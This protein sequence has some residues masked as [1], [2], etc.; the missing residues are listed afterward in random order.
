MAMVS[1]NSESSSS[2]RGLSLRENNAVK[3]CTPSSIPLCR[4]D[5]VAVTVFVD[6]EPMDEET[7]AQALLLVASFT[8]V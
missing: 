6:V 4:A 3:F 2:R 5:N 7:V 8:E 1:S